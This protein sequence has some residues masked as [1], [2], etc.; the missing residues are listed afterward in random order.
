MYRKSTSTILNDNIARIDA[1]QGPNVPLLHQD[2]T[3]IQKNQ[4]APVWSYIFQILFQVLTTI[5]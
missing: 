2:A 4:I 5:Q 1:E 3:N